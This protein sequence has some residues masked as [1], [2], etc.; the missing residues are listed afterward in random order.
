MWLNALKRRIECKWISSYKHS[1]LTQWTAIQAYALMVELIASNGIATYWEANTN[2]WRR[3]T[4]CLD[5]LLKDMTKK[6][7]KTLSAMDLAVPPAPSVIP[8]TVTIG[9]D[10]K[11]P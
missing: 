8:A 1:T 6:H 7:S 2:Q 4:E 3:F 11:S 10:C 9:N 5:F